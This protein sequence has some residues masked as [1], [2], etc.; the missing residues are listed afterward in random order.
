MRL[1]SFKHRSFPTVTCCRADLTDFPSLGC[2]ALTQPDGGAKL[3]H[4][5]TGTQKH[6]NKTLSASSV[7]HGAEMNRA[8]LCIEFTEPVGKT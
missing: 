7:K 5:S 8:G 3:P 2:N 4:A 1:K 6:R